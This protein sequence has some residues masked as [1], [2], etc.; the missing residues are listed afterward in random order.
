MPDGVES[1]SGSS[2]NKKS[3]K[4]V[5]QGTKPETCNKFNAGTCKNSDSE[6]RYRH[7][8]KLCGKSGHGKKD[9]PDG[10]K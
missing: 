1:F 6:C 7:L 10:R 2:S 4:P 5:A 3:S 9:C 8:C